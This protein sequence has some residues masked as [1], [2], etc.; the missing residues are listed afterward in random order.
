MPA[1]YTAII[2]FCSTLVVSIDKN[3]L[4]YGAKLLLSFLN[5]KIA[6]AI[7]YKNSWEKRSRN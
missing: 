6:T 7:A 2:L 1:I 5:D 4:C 3:D